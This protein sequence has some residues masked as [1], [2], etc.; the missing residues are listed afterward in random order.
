MHF[1]P[2]PF[3]GGDLAAAFLSI[4]D[5]REER[6]IGAKSRLA[7]RNRATLPHSAVCAKSAQKSANSEKARQTPC[8]SAVHRP[9]M[10]KI[11]TIQFRRSHLPRRLLRDGWWLESPPARPAVVAFPRREAPKPKPA[12]KPKFRHLTLVHPGK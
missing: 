8:Q 12:V 10:A 5:A 2:G 4:A 7:P 9:V 6:E 11:I 3:G 1:S